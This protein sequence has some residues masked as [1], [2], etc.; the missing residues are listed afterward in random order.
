M[1]VKC[2]FSGLPIEAIVGLDQRRNPELI[3]MLRDLVS[4]RTAAGRA[5]PHEVHRFIAAQ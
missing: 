4:E 1:V 5:T 3:A 2:L